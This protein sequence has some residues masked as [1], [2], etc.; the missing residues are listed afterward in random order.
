MYVKLFSSILDSSIWSENYPTRLVWITML[1]MADAEGVVKASVSGVARRAAVTREEAEAAVAILCAPDKDRPD[2]AHEGRRL[3]VV[4]GG[5]SVLNYSKYREIRTQQQFRDAARQRKHREKSRASRDMSQHADAD[6]DAKKATTG[7]PLGRLP[8]TASLGKDWE[9]AYGGTVPYGQIG[10]ACKPL[11]ERD[12]IDAVRKH[13]GHYLAATPARY[14]SPTRF[15]ETFGSWAD[16]GGAKANGA[17]VSED[18]AA[19]AFREAGLDLSQTKVRPGGYE[20]RAAL[21]KAIAARRGAAS[22]V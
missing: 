14:A 1:A 9:D 4:D 17:H 19:R 20:D 18:E 16:A 5:W 22:R 11:V 3:E 21:N 13:W 12:G 7:A 8:W 6:A 2:Q 15:A 10:K